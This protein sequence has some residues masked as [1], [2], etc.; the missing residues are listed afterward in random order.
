M[1]AWQVR[2]V[3]R[4]ENSRHIKRA[5]VERS[6]QSNVVQQ[7]KEV[8]QILVLDKCLHF[9]SMP[10]GDDGDRRVVFQ[11]HRLDVEE[12]HLIEKLRNNSPFVERR[13]TID[14]IPNVS[15]L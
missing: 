2:N 9:A 3:E 4:V 7:M 11:A 10:A 1:R 15:C 12:R 8:V 14:E 13:E 5:A 6:E